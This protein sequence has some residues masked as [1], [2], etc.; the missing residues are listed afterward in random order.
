MLF[1]SLF[2]NLR[3]NHSPAIAAAKA[4]FS[5]SA[6]YRFEKDPRLPTQKQAP[7]ER[8]RA[9]PFVDV[10]ENDVLPMLKAAPDCGRSPCSRNYAVGTRNWAPGSGGRLNGG[11]GR[12]AR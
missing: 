1:R 2:M 4:G 12:G 8:R 10:W 6:A 9:D 11:S 3:R 7:R 5:T